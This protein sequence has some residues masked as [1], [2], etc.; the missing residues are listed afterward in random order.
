MNINR[1]EFLHRSTRLACAGTALGTLTAAETIS[2]D[3][4][5]SEPLPI[6]DTHQH[7]WDL[8]KL[9]LPWLQNVQHLQRNFL[10][11]DYLKAVRGLNVVKAV[12][13]EVAAAPEQK[14]IEAEIAVELCRRTDNPTVAA[15]IGGRV[16]DDRFP[17]YIGRFK[18]S[19][20]VKG[21]RH[22][23]HRRPG[24]AGLQIGQKLIA[25]VRL[26]GKLGM[27]F[28]LCIPPET[29]SY[30]AKLAM[31]C[32]ETRIVLDH[33]GNVDPKAFVPKDRVSSP[34]E[35][36]ADR[37]RRG[38]EALAQRKNDADWWRR[39]IEMVARQENVVCK[40]SGVVARAPKGWTADD[41]APIVNHCLDTFG[42]DRVMFGSDWPVCTRAATLRQWVV[43]LRRIIAPRDISQQRKLL[44]DNAQ[45]FYALG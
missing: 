18:N 33:C 4:G 42:P 9:R 24:T 37:W 22:M 32:P 27:R 2:G 5:P 21:V 12:Y 30:G 38:I 25:G 29:L 17:E 3:D 26:L 11:A 19:P 16:D 35:S 43:A 28:D 6:I 1:R 20:Y 40:I 8:G 44:H 10:T 31:G 23:L 41:L 14:L 45:R 15:V 39:G 36:D 13:M 7:L 34:P